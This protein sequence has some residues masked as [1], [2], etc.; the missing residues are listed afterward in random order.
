MYVPKIKSLSLNITEPIIRKSIPKNATY[1]MI[2]N[3]VRAK[4]KTSVRVTT[5]VVVF[6]DGIWRYTY[7][8]PAKAAVN[9]IKFDAGK[10][11][12]PFKTVL[13]A[14]TASVRPVIFRG[15]NKR[16]RSPNKPRH[17]VRRCIRRYHGLRQLI[18]EAK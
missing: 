2:A 11:V 12:A 5:E 8:L 18:V 6:N 4:G 3:P 1:C 7:Q 17:S 15:P 16:K 9:L 14:A 13:N 10:K